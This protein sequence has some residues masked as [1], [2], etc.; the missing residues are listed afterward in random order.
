MQNEANNIYRLIHV[1]HRFEPLAFWRE[2][3]LL[4]VFPQ[5]QIQRIR[6][7]KKIETFTNVRNLII[8]IRPIEKPGAW[9]CINGTFRPII[10]E[11]D[12]FS[13]YK[14]SQLRFKKYLENPNLGIVFR[15]LF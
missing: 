14:K 3:K 12:V 10:P 8:V 11:F 2:N 5:R 13:L 9:V 4:L 6:R 15:R 7:W 1:I